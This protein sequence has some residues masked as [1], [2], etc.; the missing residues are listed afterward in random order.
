MRTALNLGSTSALTRVTDILLV[1]LGALGALLPCTAQKPNICVSKMHCSHHHQRRSVALCVCLCNLLCAQANCFCD[2]TGSFPE[3]SPQY[4]YPRQ[5][6][7]YEVATPPVIDGRLDDAAW[8]EVG[9]SEELVDISQ[10]PRPRFQTQVK[11]RWDKKFLYVAARLEEPHT[12]AN[13]TCHNEA[14]RCRFESEGR[15]PAA[16]PSSTAQCCTGHIPRQ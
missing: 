12:W 7:A 13:L 10:Q 1:P 16:C 15:C 4:T 14:S 2:F 11:V 9:W 8:T 5:L 6:L 3:L